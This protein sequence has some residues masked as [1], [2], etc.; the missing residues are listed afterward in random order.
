MVDFLD[1][2]LLLLIIFFHNFKK[3]VL[4]RVMI[5]DR[6][7]MKSVIEHIKWMWNINLLKSEIY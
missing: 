2:S 4:I 6:G 1:E 7:I 3:D 5:M